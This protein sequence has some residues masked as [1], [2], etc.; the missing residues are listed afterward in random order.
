M[1][2]NKPQAPGNRRFEKWHHKTRHI[3]QLTPQGV[4]SL[5]LSWPHIDCYNTRG[6][7]FAM[8]SPFLCLN[9]KK[10]KGAYLGAAKFYMPRPHLYKNTT[11]KINLRNSKSSQAKDGLWSWSRQSTLNNPRLSQWELEATER[12]HDFLWALVSRIVT[13]H[14]IASPGACYIFQVTGAMGISVSSGDMLSDSSSVT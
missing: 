11:F 5:D 6:S 8:V 14:G 1:L 12:E 4:F 3:E 9:G 2:P 13:L 10:K 7:S